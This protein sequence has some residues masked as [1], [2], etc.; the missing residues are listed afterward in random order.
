VFKLESS[1]ITIN[2]TDPIE[3]INS[4]ATPMSNN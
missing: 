4:R 2:K 1:T 3:K